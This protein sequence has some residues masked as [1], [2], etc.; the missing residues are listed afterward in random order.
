MR[1][2]EF[3]S[4]GVT[5]RAWL[6][7]P[8]S[9]ALRTEGGY[10]A[11]VMAHGTSGVREQLKHYIPRFTA[12]GMHVLLFDYRHFGASDG[13]PRQLLSIRRQLQDYAA[14]LDVIRK[15]PGV[16]P[17][18]VAIWGSSLAGGHVVDVAVTDGRVA[19][20]VAQAAAMDNIATVRRLVEYAG[21][22]QL[23]KLTWLGIVDVLR[24]IFGMSPKL[25]PAGA[26]PGEV[27]M[28]TTPD[29]LPGLK[30]IEAPGW[31][32]ELCGRLSLTLALHRPGL[33]AGRLPCPILIAICDEDSLVVPAVA[34]AAARRAGKLAT[35]KHYPIGHFDIYLG[36]WF[37]RSVT[38]QVKFLEETFRDTRIKS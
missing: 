37:E 11:L 38:D 17:E 24:S 4:H 34:E 5:C 18:R 36:E 23:L 3:T 1:E 32:N 16:D 33:K 31:R 25:V 29:T 26:A 20:V 28:M 2:V 13:E 7:S 30:R 27:G 9:E 12:A 14:A 10:P 8:E 22:G 15:V 21:I 19:A 6:C 35:V